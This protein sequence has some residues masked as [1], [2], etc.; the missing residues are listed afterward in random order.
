MATVVVSSLLV[1]IY[2]TC[3][4]WASSVYLPCCLRRKDDLQFE[5]V[6]RDHA[7]QPIIVTFSIGFWLSYPE[8]LG[9]TPAWSMGT[10]LAG[11]THL[12][13]GQNVSYPSVSWSSSGL[14]SPRA[15][16]SSWH[17]PF[18]GSSIKTSGHSF[19]TDIVRGTFCVV[20]PKHS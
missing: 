11:Q 6:A 8:H 10:T 4:L 12:T 15:L 13:F 20:V 19:L 16:N 3:G 5:Q 18:I 9:Q 7:K 1:K 2:A 17:W 14:M